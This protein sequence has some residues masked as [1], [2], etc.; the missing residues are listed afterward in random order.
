MNLNDVKGIV[1]INGLKFDPKEILLALV[2]Q[3]LKV[4]SLNGTLLIGRSFIDQSP[5]IKVE[6]KSCSMS[7]YCKI[8]DKLHCNSTNETEL[9]VSPSALTAQ[10]DSLN[11]FPDNFQQE[12]SKAYVEKIEIDNDDIDITN[13]FDS[14]LSQSPSHKPFMFD[15]VPSSEGSDLGD[16]QDYNSEPT[17]MMGMSPL[18]KYGSSK[19]NLNSIPRKYLGKCPYCGTTINVNW[20]FCGNCGNTQ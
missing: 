10:L 6:E 3:G 9:A 15:D 7:P 1:E 12:P 2:E 13:L 8:Y 17:E 4:H 11:Q 19:M 20:K 18:T 16:L 14:S 5:D